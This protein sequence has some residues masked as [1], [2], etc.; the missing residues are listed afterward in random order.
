MRLSTPWT[1]HLTVGEINWRAGELPDGRE[2]GP[3][4]FGKHLEIERLRLELVERNDA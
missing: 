3:V 4:E 1:V 2:V